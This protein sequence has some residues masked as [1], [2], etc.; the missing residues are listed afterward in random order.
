MPRYDIGKQPISQG[1]QP[2]GQDVQLGTVDDP[3]ENLQA[4][5]KAQRQANISTGIT[6]SMNTGLNLAEKITGGVGKNA[7]T[8]GMSAVD[9]ATK[10]MASYANIFG[11]E[12]LDSAYASGNLASTV[13][14]G[15]SGVGASIAKGGLSAAQQVTGYLGGAA[16]ILTGGMQAGKGIYDLNHSL[17]NSDLQEWAGKQ[18]NYGIAGR[19]Y[20]MLTSPGNSAMSVVN[21]RLKK[22]GIDTSLGLATAG[23]GLGSTI[24]TA[25][26]AGAGLGS[27]VPLIGTAIGTIAGLAAGLG[28]FFG[29]KHRLQKKAERMIND[30]TKSFDAYNQQSLAIANSQ[31]LRDEFR[32]A[33]GET[34]GTAVTGKQPFDPTWMV[35]NGWAHNGEFQA[36]SETGIGHKITNGTGHE[37]NAPVHAEPQDV[38]FTDKY[39]SRLTGENLAKSAEKASKNIENGNN[40]EHN[41]QIF[42]EL[43]QEQAEYQSIDNMKKFGKKKLFK[44]ARGYFAPDAINA[45]NWLTNSSMNLAQHFNLKGQGIYD[46]NPYVDN[47]A[48]VN[49]IDQAR[50]Y[51]DYSALDQVDDVYR[52]ARYNALHGPYS[53]GNQLM[54]NASLADSMMKNKAQAKLAA[55]QQYFTNYA[56]WAKEKAG[57]LDSAAARKMQANTY[58]DEAKRKAHSTKYTEMAKLMASQIGNNNAFAQNAVNNYM[59]RQNLGLWQQQLDRE[60]PVKQP[61]VKTSK[62]QIKPTSV[63]PW[64][65]SVNPNAPENERGS[66]Y[67]MYPELYKALLNLQYK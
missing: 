49:A 9:A 44:A 37:E 2:G 17:T 57:L 21:Q 12:A 23:G 38:I 56:Q 62:K 40:V 59:F 64:T 32:A 11:Q 36:D 20:K 67:N 4:M 52:Q 14:D 58:A 66:F 27:T 65:E 28:T 35:Q 15:L 16:G 53:A 43:M 31:G 25:V 34:L 6:D 1:Y 47:S 24:G 33:H 42:D 41:K 60:K 61:K 45:A 3:G 18:T 22:A 13:K 7:G 10:N 39:I 63:A 29:K 55:D 50:P 26:A 5:A 48:A 8:L 54:L 46:Y 30:Q 19:Q 51:K